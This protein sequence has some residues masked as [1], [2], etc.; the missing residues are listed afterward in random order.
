METASSARPRRATPPARA[1]WAATFR[2]AA[3][4]G[5]QNMFQMVCLA[6]H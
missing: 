6:H 5:R 2:S 4:L 3:V 1:W